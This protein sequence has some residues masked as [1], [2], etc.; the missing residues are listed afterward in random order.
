MS[1][2]ILQ[3]EVASNLFRT[4]DITNTIESENKHLFPQSMVTLLFFVN[5]WIIRF[6]ISPL[7][8]AVMYIS[9]V[10][11]DW[12]WIQLSLK[13]SFPSAE[14]TC[15][16]KYGTIWIKDDYSLLLLSSRRGVY[17]PSPPIWPGLVTLL[18]P[19]KNTVKVTLLQLAFA[20][21]VLKLDN[22]LWSS[23]NWTVEWWE[24]TLRWQRLFCWPKL[25]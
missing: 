17:F 20:L 15:K 6:T 24:S 13:I 10:N 19:I 25:S 22:V 12:S 4:F 8:R 2:L 5:S 7:I 21:I 16:C 14:Y 11:F 1:L 3:P 18:W 9:G 23:L